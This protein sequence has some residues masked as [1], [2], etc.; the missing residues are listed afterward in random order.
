MLFEYVKI[1]IVVLIALGFALVLYMV[2]SLIYSKQKDINQMSAYEC[3][4]QPFV[5]SINKFDVRYYLVA[6]LF[7]LF[8]LEIMFLIP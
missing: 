7:I 6:L 3:G 1:L 2:S 8:D 5:E 4:F